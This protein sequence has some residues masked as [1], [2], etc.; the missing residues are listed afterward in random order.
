MATASPA[1]QATYFKEYVKNSVNNGKR[2][3][4]GKANTFF[5]AAHPNIFPSFNR[6]ANAPWPEAVDIFISYFYSFEDVANAYNFETTTQKTA[7]FADFLKDKQGQ[8]LEKWWKSLV[9]KLTRYLYTADADGNLLIDKIVSG[10]REGITYANLEPHELETLST[11]NDNDLKYE[12][13]HAY[14]KFFIHCMHLQYCHSTVTAQGTSIIEHTLESKIKLQILNVLLEKTLKPESKEIKLNR[15]EKLFD[16]VANIAKSEKS[17]TAPYFQ[18]I[19]TPEANYIHACIARAQLSQAVTKTKNTLNYLNRV[20][21]KIVSLFT[22]GFFKPRLSDQSC[23]KEALT[24][25]TDATCK[26]H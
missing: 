17:V 10:I 20:V 22:L 5:D 12:I 24:A 18:Y 4:N 15:A 2:F 19:Q 13:T 11:K 25:P 9:Y 26:L 7:F 6:L 8:L 23:I 3:P 14:I 1:L 21:E 16:T